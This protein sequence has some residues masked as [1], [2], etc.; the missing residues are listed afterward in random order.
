MGIS[1]SNSNSNSNRRRNS[2]L[3][4]PH[5]PPP[6]YYSHSHPHPP[7]L[8]PPPPPQGY[9][10]TPSTTSYVAPSPSNSMP[11][12]ANQCHPPPP[13]LPPPPPYVDHQS[14]KK[15]RNDV[16]L[17]KHTLQLHLDRNNPDHHLISFVFDAHFDGSITILYLAK[18]EE[19]CRFIPLFP[20]A[21][22]P[23]TF[24]FHKG[25]GQKFCQPSGTGI[26]LGFF[27]L[28]DLS[29]PS[30][31][32]DV[33]PLVICAETSLRTPLA[34]ETLGDSMLN[35]SPH[36]QVT[37]AVLEKANDNGPFQVKV[38][39]Q[40]LWIDDV[41]YELRELYGIGSSTATDFD[42]N[43]P[44][45]ECVIC[46]TEPKDTAVLP[47]RHMCMCS[48]CA[49]ALRFQSNKCPI[50]RQPIEELIE[51]KINNDDQ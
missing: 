7:P 46:M 43:D 32:E 27:E 49:K 33:Y 28:D 29:N 40:I 10:F 38:V 24:P 22:E 23:I 11:F 51:I 17:H 34:D 45:K 48:D 6:Y 44:G 19:K 18:E 2:Y 16:N 30:P 4:H 8:L 42:D 9:F 13:P 31:G 15:I 39:R 50:C 37:Q 47:C 26:D 36:M 20:D 21:F 3:D 12:Y 5:L 1:W 35:A 25:L 41:R 14:A